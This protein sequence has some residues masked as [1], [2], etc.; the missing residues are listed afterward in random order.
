MCD[1]LSIVIWIILQVTCLSLENIN[2]SKRSNKILNLKKELDIKL[3][4]NI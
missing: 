1:I 2:S 4:S 3:Y